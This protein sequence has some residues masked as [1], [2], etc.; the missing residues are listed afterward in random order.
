MLVKN[1]TR[2]KTQT[3]KE[4]IKRKERNEIANKI[5]KHERTKAWRTP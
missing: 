1:A 5:R 2:M 3:N 4:T